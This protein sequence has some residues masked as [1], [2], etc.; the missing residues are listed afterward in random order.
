MSVHKYS[1][2]TGDRIAVESAAVGTLYVVATPIGNLEDMSPRAVRILHEVSL[3]AAEDTRHSQRLLTHFHITTPV[4]SYH[5]HNQAER[6]A[7]LLQ[8]LGTGDV[9]LIS[10]AGTP[11]VSDPGMD[12][13]RAAIE[14]GH[15]VSA[16]PGPSAV[17][18]AVSVS[19]LIE[20]PFVVLG[21]LPRERGVRKVLLGRAVASGWPLVIFEAA[22]RLGRTLGELL[23]VTGNRRA[24]VVRELTKVYEEVRSGDLEQLRAWAQADTVRGEIVLVVAGAEQARSGRDEIRAVLQTLLKSGLSASQAAREAAVMTGVAR[25][26]LYQLALELRKEVSVGLEGKLALPDQHALQEALSDQESPEG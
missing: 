12:L 8:A 5:Q 20:G 19:G 2:R 21:F 24:T 15:C 17:A 16:I 18:A 14:S 1:G 7:H 6:R 26:E 23:L 25:S 13:V 4:L 10:D 11:A 22:N 9:A 3:I